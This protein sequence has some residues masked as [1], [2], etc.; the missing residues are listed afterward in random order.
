MPNGDGDSSEQGMES[1]DNSE[2]GK[3]DI[4]CRCVSQFQ[5][6]GKTATYV[7]KIRPMCLTFL[8]G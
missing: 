1:C 2:A 7:V 6:K 3:K 8:D 4:C 5:Q